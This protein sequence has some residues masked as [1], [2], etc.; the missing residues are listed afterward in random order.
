LNDRIPG[1]G[2][3]NPIRY[4]EWSLYIEDPEARDCWRATLSRHSKLFV[5]DAESETQL[6]RMIDDFWEMYHSVRPQ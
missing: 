1:S 4:R 6:K 2:P 3:T 5:I